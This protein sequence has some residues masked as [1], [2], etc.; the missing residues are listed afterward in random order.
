MKI[1][2]KKRKLGIFLIVV[3]IFFCSIYMYLF[4]GPKISNISTDIEKGEEG[5]KSLV[6]YFTRKDVVDIQKVDAESSASVNVKNGDF[7]GNT[8]ILARKIA[9]MTGADIFAIKTRHQ[10][11]NSFGGTAATAWV[12]E[13]LK[14]QPKLAVIP[15]NLNAYDI[16]YVGYPIWWFNAPMAI[17]S[18]LSNY[19]LSGKTVIPFCTSEDNGIDV[20]EDYIQEV[21]GDATVLEGIRFKS[22]EVDDKTLQNWL[23]SIKVKGGN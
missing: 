19:N 23:N 16:I 22:N 10:Y 1:K 9:D 2:N 11:R 20:S 3:L 8:E 17:G 7:E 4:T 15:D 14:I 5:T 21:S 13:K 6:V 12:E 18:F